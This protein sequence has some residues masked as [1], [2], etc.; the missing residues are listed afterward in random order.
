[1]THIKH[2]RFGAPKP[3]QRA[4]RLPRAS[5]T[6]IDDRQALRAIVTAAIT[7]RGN[8]GVTITIASPRHRPSSA[9]SR[10]PASS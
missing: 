8:H 2:V 3:R 4:I 5:A 6:G 10:H 1:M 7:E 9:E